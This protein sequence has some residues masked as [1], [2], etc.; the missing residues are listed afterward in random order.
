M[1][2]RIVRA[3]VDVPYGSRVLV[4]SGRAS[5]ADDSLANATATPRP[6][7][8]MENGIIKA[9]EHFSVVMDEGLGTRDLQAIADGPIMDESNLYLPAGKISMAEY[10]ERQRA[11]ILGDEP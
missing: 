6:S 10:R 4:R 2:R 8:L 1:T 11:I 9:G 3:D 7:W 5:P